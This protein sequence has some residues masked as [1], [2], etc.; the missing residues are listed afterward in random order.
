MEQLS[1]IQ[2]SL[3]VEGDN[4]PFLNNTFAQ[5]RRIDLEIDLYHQQHLRSEMGEIRSVLLRM[6]GE[7][8]GHLP[9]AT[10]T[11]NCRRE[12]EDVLDTE[13][14]ASEATQIR[15]EPQ[16]LSPCDVRTSTLN[17]PEY[18]YLF[19]DNFAET[20]HELPSYGTAVFPPTRRHIN[21]VTQRGFDS[22]AYFHTATTEG[23]HN[24]KYAAGNEEIFYCPPLEVDPPPYETVL[25]KPPQY[26]SLQVAMARK[27]GWN[28]LD[29]E[30]SENDSVTGDDVS[31]SFVTNPST[32]YEDAKEYIY[33]SD[34]SS[35]SDGSNP[36]DDSSVASETDSQLDAVINNPD[37]RQAL[38]QLCHI[39]ARDPRAKL[40]S[41]QA[42]SMGIKRDIQTKCHSQRK[43]HS[44][45]CDESP[46]Q[47]WSIERM[48]AHQNGGSL[49][50]IYED[51][52]EPQPKI[53]TK[54][55]KWI[56]NVLHI[57][58]H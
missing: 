47:P 5:L 50:L 38:S 46:K 7:L 32:L 45:P 30:S 44:T 3:Q 23:L 36:S 42:Q 34:N 17:G 21:H 43:W 2:E 18:N 49:D 13:S 15:Y 11:T 10:P 20:T 8:S 58:T 39:F 16:A 26:E 37:F 53:T 54:D 27:R 6:D 57:V 1:L 40:S 52:A 35:Q 19:C 25:V 51:E 48:W 55:E 33:P 31:T 14:S 56:D 12:Q 22:Q 24:L 4:L 28:T 9:I 41:A 29:T